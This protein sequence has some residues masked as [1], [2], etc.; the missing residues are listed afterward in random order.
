M[1]G[2]SDPNF[3]SNRVTDTIIKKAW[4]NRIKKCRAVSAKA[5]KRSIPA[6]RE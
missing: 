1:R 2:L 3:M 4:K 5:V 6:I